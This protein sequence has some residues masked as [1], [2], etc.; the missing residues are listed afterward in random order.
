MSRGKGDAERGPADADGATRSSAGTTDLSR[1]SVLDAGVRAGLALG[2]G[3]LLMP[4]LAGIGA[5]ARAQRVV[6]REGEG[7]YGPLTA[8]GPEIALP[9]GFRYRVFGIEGSIMSDGRPT[10]RSHDGM[11]AFPLPNGN[12][13]LIRNHEDATPAH[14]ATPIGDPA[15]AYD[16]L[17]P[18]GTTS[19]EVRPDGD[20]ELV[21]DFVSLSGTI[22]N[23][24]GGPTPW[25]S[26][27][28]CEEATSG[29][30]QGWEREHGYVFE[31]SAAAQTQVEA[32]PLKALGRFT[33][34]ALAFDPADGTVYLTEDR[35]E[36]GFYRFVPDAPGDLSRGRLQMLAVGGR[37]NLDTAQG[38]TVGE[39]LYVHWVDID[40]VDPPGTALNPSAVFFQGRRQ[41]AA[42]FSRLEGCWY[43]RG[44]IFFHATTG[45]DAEAGQVWEYRPLGPD[46]GLL[47]L[48]FE[49]PGRDVLDSP[50][51]LTVSPRGGLLM[52]EDGWGSNYLR[53]L[54]P[55]GRIFDFAQ[56]LANVNEFA[57]ATFS[58][59][60]RTLFVNV[61]GDK[62]VGGEGV[63]GSTFAIWGP[64][65]RGGL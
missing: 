11:A 27:L 40:E 5:G 45:G 36:A 6:A 32:V 20:R 22:W 18:G 29:P 56:N 39:P 38:Q 13:R 63:L 30:G 31:I 2:A 58:P 16:P 14:L 60:G 3:R 21:R 23:C 37:P 62:R 1:R 50:D 59:D 48:F 19:L 12:V 15:K 51:N 28:T 61:Q 44:S 17:A 8:A 25:G 41:G 54:T 57:G 47:V 52:C 4:G 46:E 49:S 64:W 10:P 65:E 9:E 34:E 35:T 42:S 7:G 24:A 53:G 43:G 55:D 33:H 26:W